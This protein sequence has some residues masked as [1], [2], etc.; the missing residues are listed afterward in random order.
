M[1]TYL[2]HSDRRYGLP[3][4]VRNGAV[5]AL[6]ANI[7][8]VFDLCDFLGQLCR[9]QLRR[10]LCCAS[11]GRRSNSFQPLALLTLP[12]ARSTYP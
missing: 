3:D 6:H 1:S 10:G 9:H 11:G 8:H 12:L 4:Y 7:H 2:G 5:D